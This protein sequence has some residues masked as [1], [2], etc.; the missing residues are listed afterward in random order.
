M[1]QTLILLL[2]LSVFLTGC[3]EPTI[4]TTTEDSMNSSIQD[5]RNSLEPK[6]QDEFDNAMKII[7]FSNIN[8]SG[9]FVA[10]FS[11]DVPNKEDM[12]NALKKSLNGK[13]AL[14]IISEAQRIKEELKK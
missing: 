13:T 9:I 6:N 10:A 7:M 8:M 14:E 4:D 2:F 3:N 12:I 1:K 5:V 11:G